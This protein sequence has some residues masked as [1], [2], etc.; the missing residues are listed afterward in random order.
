MCFED[1]FFDFLTARIEAASRGL[2]R[3]EQSQLP[4]LMCTC[5]YLLTCAYLRREAVERVRAR[6]CNPLLRQAA[7]F[8]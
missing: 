1:E 7:P 8:E 4:R 6:L 2:E 5:I 3:C